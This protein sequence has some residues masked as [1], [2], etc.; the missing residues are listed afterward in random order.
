MHIGR[1]MRQNV[2]VHLVANLQLLV[3]IVQIVMAVYVQIVEHVIIIVLAHAELV[4]N[5]VQLVQRFVR[6]AIYV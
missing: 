3:G 1:R 6:F 4:L 5:A 2:H